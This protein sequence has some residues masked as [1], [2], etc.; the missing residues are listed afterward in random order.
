MGAN[1]TIYN[2]WASTVMN[3]VFL[4]IARQRSLGRNT[5]AKSRAVVVVA[6]PPDLHHHGGL[7]LAREA[8]P[9]MVLGGPTP[10]ET[11]Y[12]VP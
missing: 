8:L 4:L 9:Y 5:A 7:P 12:T 1:D 2:L 3:D 10:F 11:L 6:V